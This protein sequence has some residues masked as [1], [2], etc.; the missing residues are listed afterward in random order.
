MSKRRF[1]TTETQRHGEEVKRKI[2]GRF[3]AFSFLLS[4]LLGVGCG[5]SGQKGYRD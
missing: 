3:F 2:R 4:S 5:Y 1:F